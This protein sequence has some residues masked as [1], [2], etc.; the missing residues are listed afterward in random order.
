MSFEHHLSPQYHSNILIPV[1]NNLVILFG[2]RGYQPM[3]ADSDIRGYLYFVGKL[4]IPNTNG[5]CSYKNHLHFVMEP[6]I[7]NT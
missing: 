4:Y 2:K 7:L 3:Y 5:L 6:F 1:Y